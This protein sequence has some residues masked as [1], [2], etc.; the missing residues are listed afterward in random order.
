LTST[1][2]WGVRNSSSDSSV[3]MSWSLSTPLRIDWVDGCAH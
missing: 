2:W 3:L 1:F